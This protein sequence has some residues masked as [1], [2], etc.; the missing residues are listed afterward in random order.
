MRDILHPKTENDGIPMNWGMLGDK[1]QLENM[2]E[3]IGELEKKAGKK[4][5]ATSLPKYEWKAWKI[6]YQHLK[7]HG[8]QLNLE[9]TVEG[10]KVL[11]PRTNN[12]SETG[13]REVKRKA[14]RTTG[15]KNLSRY[16]DDLPAQYAYITNLDD[17]EY[18]KIVFGDQ[19]DDLSIDH[20]MQ[21][22]SRIVHCF[23]LSLRVFL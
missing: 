9:I 13:F 23:A 6:I 10:R 22:I 14:R 8:K 4:V 18:V 7:K 3:K 15:K 2:E 12:L 1:S 17:P 5:K 19:K 16:M 11:L 21:I 20:L